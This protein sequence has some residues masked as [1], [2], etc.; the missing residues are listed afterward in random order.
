MLSQEEQLGFSKQ[1]ELGHPKFKVFLSRAG[2]SAQKQ[3]RDS[4]YINGIQIHLIFPKNNG[5]IQAT[6][7]ELKGLKPMVISQQQR[8]D[9]TRKKG[10]ETTKKW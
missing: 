7:V 3:S 10:F 1:W 8:S 9:S 2:R 5:L 4:C 6:T